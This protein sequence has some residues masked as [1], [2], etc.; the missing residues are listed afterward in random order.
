MRT[1]FERL[2]STTRNR[3]TSRQ[4]DA[5]AGILHC[6]TA[7][8]KEKIRGFMFNASCSGVHTPFLWL[9]LAW[10]ETPMKLTFGTLSDRL[11]TVAR[12]WW[13]EEKSGPWRL[14]SLEECAR[15]GASRHRTSGVLET[16]GLQASLCWASW[17]MQG[18]AGG[19][20]HGTEFVCIRNE[21]IIAS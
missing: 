6:A 21:K 8:Q 4:V 20:G 12:Y 16:M 11:R 18:E 14:L 3:E 10:D 15:K 7:H 1:A 5:A 17:E 13:R 19:D 9:S 2:R